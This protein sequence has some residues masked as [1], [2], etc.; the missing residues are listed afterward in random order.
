M[1]YVKVA[2]DPYFY[3]PPFCP[4][5]SGSSLVVQPN[6]TQTQEC[7][8]CIQPCQAGALQ[9]RHLS[10]HGAHIWRVLWV[11]PE[12]TSHERLATYSLLALKHSCT[13]LCC[14]IWGFMPTDRVTWAPLQ[15]ASSGGA[16]PVGGLSGRPEGRK[17]KVLPA[18]V[19]PPRA[20]APARWP[21]IRQLSRGSSNTSLLHSPRSPSNLGQ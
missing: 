20:T 12:L 9:S 7:W 15:L 1:Q 3:T 18:C 11:P 4:P 19:P 10:R 21:P 8:R 6:W 16:Q 13:L 14:V 5:E 17:R 2:M